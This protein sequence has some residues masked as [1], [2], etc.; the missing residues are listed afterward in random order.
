MSHYSQPITSAAESDDKSSLIQNLVA[1]IKK[2]TSRVQVFEGNKGVEGLNYEDLCV[3]PDVE[4][5]E[6]YKPPKFEMFDGIGDPRV[7]L[8][9]Y[10]DKLVGVGRDEKIRMKL[11]MRSLKGDSLSWYISQ[12]AKKWTSWVNM[13]SDFMD[14]FR[15]NTENTP[16]VFYIQNLKK[17]PTETFREYASGWRSEAAKDPKYYERLMLIE[18]QKFSDII[19]LGERIKK[20][21]K[22]GMVTNLEALQ[23]TNKALQSGGSSKKKDVNSV[24]VAQRNNSPMKYQTYLSAPLTYQPTLNYQ[25][26]SP[27]YQIPPPAY[28]L[29][30]PPTYQPTSPRYSQPAPVC[31][32][33]N[34]Q[35]SHYPSPPTRQNFPRPRLNFDR[36][37]PRQYTAIAEPID[38]LYKKLKAAGYVTLI[39]AVT[40]ENPSQ[41]INP[42]KTCAYHSGMKGHT[43]DECRSLKEKIQ[44][45]I[46]NKIIIAKEPAP[47]VRNNPL[48]DHKGR[49]IHMIEI[50]DDWD[51]KWSISLIVEGDKPKK[52]AVTLNPIV[53]QIQ[54]SKGDVV[55]VSVPLEFEAPSAKAPKPIEVEFGIP[56]APTPVEVTVLPHK[57]PIPVSMTDMTPFKLKAIPWDYTAEARRKGKTHTGEAV[58]AQGMTRTGR[59]YTPEHL[60]E[61]SKQASGRPIETGPDDLWIK[62]QAKEYSVVEQLNK[63]PAQISILALLQ[64]SE[65]NKNA[66]MKILSEAYVPSNITGG[67]MANMVGKVLESHKITFHEDELPPEGLGHNKALHITTQCEDH[68]ITRILVDGGSSLNIC[69]LITLRTLGKGLHEVKDGAISIKAFDGSQR[70]TIGEISLCLQMGPT[71]FDVKFQVIDEVIIHGDG[72]NPIY[73]RQTIPIGGETYHHIERVNS[74]D[75]DKWWDNKIESILNWSGYEPGKG[76]GKNLQGITKPIKLKKH[77]TTFGLGYEYTWEEFNHWSPPWCRPYYSLEHPTPQLEQTFQPTDTL[78]GSEEDE[79]LAAIKNLFLEDDMDCCVIFEEEGRK[80]LPFKPITI[81][82]LDDEPTTVTCNKAMQQTDMDSKE[83][84]IPEEVVREVENFEN[85]P[86]S[87]LDETEVVNLG[88]TENVKETR[89]SAHL[90][91]S[92][93]K[94]YTEFLKE[95]EDIL[96]CSQ[97]ANRSYMSAGRAEAQEVQARHKFED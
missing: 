45:L 44:N 6:G 38:Q 62:I 5:P 21:T 9:M 32:A 20:G 56:K 1:K 86:K 64:S 80:A 39:P 27:T 81:T 24:M 28:Q 46:D 40:P 7:H 47:N 57:V 73:S 59:V 74:V 82:Y 4:L 76:L 31:Q 15:F 3:Q 77:G 79:A 71:W 8:R 83:D 85:R 37:P 34:S 29:P 35:L 67:E 91:P 16:D 88:D 12:D 87:N 60:A 50:Q 63:M 69:P 55:N 19:K 42:N 95:Y 26:P 65:A 92:E 58:A 70:S 14:R 10:C 49:S 96:A 72:S 2:L 23:A 36:K 93:K 90:S 53:V 78:Y 48:H 97:V 18:G 33:Y 30:P 89:I 94:E 54:P 75:K 22:N 68:F 11:F 61:S 52:P 17:K 13:V 51:P 84:E 41:W 66:L 25:A 43:I